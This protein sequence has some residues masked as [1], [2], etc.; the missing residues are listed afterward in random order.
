MCWTKRTWIVATTIGATEVLKDHGLCRWNY[1]LH[2]LHQ[3]TKDKLISFSSFGK[4]ANSSSPSHINSSR[5]VGKRRARGKKLKQ[6]AE[7]S[8]RKI[9]YLSS[10]GPY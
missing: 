7:E 1:S 3:R 9:M 10:W 2:L 6:S 8:V 4:L 5:T